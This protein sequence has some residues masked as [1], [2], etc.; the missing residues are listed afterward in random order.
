MTKADP[1]GFM[2]MLGSDPTPDPILV[3]KDLQN[4]AV[5]MRVRV[6]QLHS[7]TGMLIGQKYL[8]ARQAGVTG[9][10]HGY[11]SG[12]GGD[13]WWMKHDDGTESAYGIREMEEI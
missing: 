9:T 6:T 4:P 11:V 7:T 3:G 10:L 5:G 1:D 13:V 8:D 2:P 12:H